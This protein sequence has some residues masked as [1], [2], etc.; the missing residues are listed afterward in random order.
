M[1]KMQ[2]SSFQRPQQRID[3]GED[4]MRKLREHHRAKITA[5]DEA[6]QTAFASP[7]TTRKQLAAA[8]SALEMAVY[9]YEH[10]TPVE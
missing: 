2:K 10:G 4:R 5:A 9:N 1:P 6:F 8:I 3:D 7:S